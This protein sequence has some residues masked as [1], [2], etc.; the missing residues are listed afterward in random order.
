MKLY[1]DLTF[2]LRLS[3]QFHT[4][5]NTSFMDWRMARFSNEVR[6]LSSSLL[7]PTFAKQV[8]WS[9][10]RSNALESEGLCKTVANRCPNGARFEKRASVTFPPTSSSTPSLLRGSFLPPST[11]LLRVLTQPL[12]SLATS[13]SLG[14]F[15]LSCLSFYTVTPFSLSPARLPFCTPCPSLRW[16]CCFVFRISLPCSALRWHRIKTAWH[17]VIRWFM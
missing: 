13:H 8:V 4:F 5:S 12:H 6:A 1:T 7:V 16:S 10:V 15:L 2:Y 11:P 9:S 17:V 3:L 14:S